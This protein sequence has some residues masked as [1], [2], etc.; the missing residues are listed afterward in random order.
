MECTPYE[1]QLMPDNGLGSR[2]VVSINTPLLRIQSLSEHH[3]I[4]SLTPLVAKVLM[5]FVVI[6][7]R[8]HTLH[9][10]FTH[11]TFPLVSRPFLCT[12]IPTSHLSLGLVVERIIQ[13]SDLWQ[14][15]FSQNPLKLSPLPPLSA[16]TL[17]HLCRPCCTGIQNFSCSGG[18]SEQ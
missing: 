18:T 1:N 15:W 2:T 5:I 6:S 17:S 4:P 12:K 13:G 16:T 9:K 11:R 10:V 14:T 8:T 3:R 7:R